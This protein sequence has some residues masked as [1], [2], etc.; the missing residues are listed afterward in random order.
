M[1]RQVDTAARL[2][3]VG[4]AVLSLAVDEG[5]GAVTIRAVA[6]RIG[7][8]TSVVTH[9][10]GGRDNMLRTAIRRQ[11]DLRRAEGEAVLDVQGRTGA[12]ALRAL[13]EWAVLTPDEQTHRVWLALVLGS[14][15]EPVLRAELDLFNDWWDGCIRRLLADA[16]IAETDIEAV[17]DVLDVV[18]DGLVVTG[19]DEGRPWSTARRERALTALWATLE[20]S[21]F[22]SGARYL[23]E[24][25]ISDAPTDR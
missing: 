17:C 16:G 22:G 12:A 6:D 3:A 10:V 2:V 18:V 5:F 8:S 1:P 14:H 13:I 15:A 24:P 9:Y 11:I 4:E 20:S 25:P 23:P 21:A 7:A 19:F